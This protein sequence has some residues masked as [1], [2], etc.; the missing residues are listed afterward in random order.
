M[1]NHMSYPHINRLWRH[2]GIAA[3]GLSFACFPVPK[4]KDNSLEHTLVPDGVILNNSKPA[5][6]TLSAS[7]DFVQTDYAA[8]EVARTDG[9]LVFRGPLQADHPLDITLPIPTKDDEVVVKLMMPGRELIE[10]VSIV[11][12]AGAKDFK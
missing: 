5:T 10:R 1:V 8:I 9:T 2:A 4:A 11:G 6:L 3:L 7:R 12:G